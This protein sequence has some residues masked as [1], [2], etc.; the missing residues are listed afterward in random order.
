APIP[1]FSPARPPHSPTRPASPSSKSTASADCP[2]PPSDGL[3]P[4]R[5][6]PHLLQF[7]I[8]RSA[9]G[10]SAFARRRLCCSQL[11][12]DFLI[13]NSSL[14][15]VETENEHAQIETEQEHR[16]KITRWNQRQPS[17]RW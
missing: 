4:W 13:L 10:V 2:S 8:G 11:T 6:S 16:I 5:A 14:L 1:P 17:W 15:L 9:F 12:R 3:V 7:D